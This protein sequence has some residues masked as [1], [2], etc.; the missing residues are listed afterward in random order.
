MKDLKK[1][2]YQAM[3]NFLV[4]SNVKRNVEQLNQ[5]R[6]LFVERMMKIINKAEKAGFN[7][8]KNHDYPVAYLTY[9]EKEVIKKDIIKKLEKT[10]HE[11]KKLINK[12]P[13]GEDFN[14]SA[15]LQSDIQTI[16][17]IINNIK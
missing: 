9:Q 16:E 14:P 15:F 5:D 11:K 3:D 1:Q 2:I 8:C 10:I 7:R 17:D 12:S 4:E 6:H 13:K